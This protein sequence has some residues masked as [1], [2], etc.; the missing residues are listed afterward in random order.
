MKR[1]FLFQVGLG[2]WTGES[3]CLPGRYFFGTSRDEVLLRLRRQLQE[4]QEELIKVGRPAMEDEGE[5]LI[6]SLGKA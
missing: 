4:R 6:V 5:L 1:L 3:P 2:R